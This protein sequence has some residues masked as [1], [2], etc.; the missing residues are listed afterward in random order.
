MNNLEKSILKTIAFGDIFNYPLTTTEIYKWLFKPEKIKGQYPS[1]LA[2]RNTLNN[3]EIIKEKIS[4]KEGFYYLKGR[5]NTIYLRKQNNNLAESKF[6]RIVSL[7]KIYRFIPFVRMIAVCNSL[8]ISNAN[9]NSDIDLFII[10]KKD[11][12]WLAR[13]FTV[14]LVKFF[15]LRPREDKSKDTFCLSFFID[16]DYLNIK[17]II[18][19]NNDIYLPHWIQQLIP[20]YNPDYLYEKFM[21]A[22]EW[23]KEYLPN[24]YNNEF[25]YE[26]KETYLSRFYNIIISSLFSI[27]FISYYLH[28]ILRKIQILIIDRNLKSLVNLNTKVIVNNQMLKFHD[29]DRRDIFFKQ[30]KERLSKLI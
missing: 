5:R 10:A 13:F 18:L 9:E 6:S 22:N 28:N 29:N 30:W 20:I 27:P 25:V 26:V 3:S 12:I 14:I 24:G 21:K 4:Q 16:E 2:I 23:Y 8:A 17:N 19:N 15:D 1:L 7:I 11:K